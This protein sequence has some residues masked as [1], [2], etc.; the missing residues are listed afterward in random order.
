MNKL[1][2]IQIEFIMHKFIR[3]VEADSPNWEEIAI[4]LLTNGSCIIPQ[5]YSVWS[6]GI[7][8]FIKYNKASNFVECT[9]CVFDL[10]G[11]LKSKLFEEAYET[12]I[13]LLEDEIDKLKE[14]VKE[15]TNLKFL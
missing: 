9:E 7:N 5:T 15:I 10:N 11:F 13:T 1:S 4:K 2:E 14:Q 8:N 6:G 3:N 12:R